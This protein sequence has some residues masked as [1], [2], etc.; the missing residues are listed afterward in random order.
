MVAAELSLKGKVR[1]AEFGW[2]VLEDD[3]AELGVK[4]VVS[5]N[6]LLVSDQALCDD[7][8]VCL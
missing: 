8:D 7:P 1:T 3:I 4:S 2:M 6:E 5:L